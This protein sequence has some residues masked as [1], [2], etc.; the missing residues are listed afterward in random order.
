MSSPNWAK[1]VNQ[2]RAKAWGIPW[3]EEE[4]HARALGIP[5]EYVRS[6]ILTVEDYEAAKI[7]DAKNG[8][9]LERKDRDELIKLAK[10]EGIATLTP[11][12]TAPA[13]VDVLKAKKGKKK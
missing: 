8:K 3:A 10:E 13:I 9:P 12:A 4:A 6:G 7:T 2:G 1:L 11:D 5:A